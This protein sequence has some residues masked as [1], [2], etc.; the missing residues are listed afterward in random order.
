M[1]LWPL[2]ND[3]IP[4][5]PDSGQSLFA[6]GGV[7]TS[8]RVNNSASGGASGLLWLSYVTALVD[9]PPITKLAMNALANAAVGTTLA[10]MALFTV[11][12]D[13]SITK[14]AQTANDTTIGT[15][16]YTLY[17]RMLST[18]GGFP[19]SYAL[20]AGTRY[21]MGYL[22]VATTVPDLSGANLMASNIPPI[23]SRKVEGQTDIAA[24]YAVASLDSFYFGAWLMARP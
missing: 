6:K 2:R 4:H 7:A 1:A 22:H 23:A 13:D 15:T 11:A 18:V 17:E 9:T 12:P 16:T 24:S 5:V 3:L 20:V 14:V 8:T 21:A 10:R 19:S